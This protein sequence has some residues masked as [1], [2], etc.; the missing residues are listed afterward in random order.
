MI[1]AFSFAS[2]IS[3]SVI[4]RESGLIWR[5]S[6]VRSFLCWEERDF[7]RRGRLNEG[8]RLF[9]DLPYFLHLFGKQFSDAVIAETNL[10]EGKILS[11]CHLGSCSR[12]ETYQP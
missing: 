7:V 6:S 11:K 3:E 9:E 10:L 4:S 12:L 8:G 1:L 5:F 2:S